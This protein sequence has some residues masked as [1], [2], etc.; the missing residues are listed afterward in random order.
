MSAHLLAHED[1]RPH[2]PVRGLVQLG[3]ADFWLLI[4]ILGGTLA[5]VALVFLLYDWSR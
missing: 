4:G 2:H 5:L 1:E 3:W